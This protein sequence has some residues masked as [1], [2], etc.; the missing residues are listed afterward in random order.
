MP[1]GF[2][3]R[4]NVFF[5]D[6][7]VVCFVVDLTYSKTDFQLS[8]F[9]ETVDGVRNRHSGKDNAAKQTIQFRIL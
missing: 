4:P 5:R 9:A 1:K 8:D 7:R 3:V 2:H 6:Y